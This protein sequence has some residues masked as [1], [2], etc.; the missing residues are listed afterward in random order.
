MTFAECCYDPLVARLLGSVVVVF[1]A[2]A[3]VGTGQGAEPRR[4]GVVARAAADAPVGEAELGRAASAALSGQEVVIDPVD[5][6]AAK[7]AAGAI[8]RERLDQLRRAQEL[9]DEGWRAYLKVEAAF[10]DAR[11]VA[12]RRTL[13]EVL[14]LDGAYELLADATLRLGAVRLFSRRQPEAQAAF[15]LAAALDPERDPGPKDFA[16]A[17]LE[18]YARAKATRT[19]GVP[20]QVVVP[21]VT[22]AEVE[23]DGR[24]VGAAPARVDVG[25]GEHVVVARARGRVSAGRI[26]RA[27]EGPVEIELEPDLVGNA[28]A[29]GERGLRPG[30]DA[31]AA[32]ATL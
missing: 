19:G 14:D 25:V 1:V 11:L 28:L 6:A 21:G 20:L 3:G 4:V 32:T 29:G 26:V 16:P 10:A 8:Q 13:E 18:A 30:T 2:G 7:R 24:P 5:Q 17:V 9:V 27:G 31:S 23:V 15:V 12:A 22:A